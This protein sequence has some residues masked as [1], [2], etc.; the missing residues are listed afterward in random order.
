MHTKDKGV[1][2]KGQQNWPEVSGTKTNAEAKGEIPERSR[3]T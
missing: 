2:I 3:M 1:P